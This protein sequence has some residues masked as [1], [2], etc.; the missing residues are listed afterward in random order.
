MKEFRRVLILIFLVGPLISLY[1]TFVLK[2][3]WNWFATEAL[4]LPEIPFWVM[5]GL[6][7]MIGMFTAKLD[8]IEQK[9]TFK[10]F[11]TALDACVPSDQKEWVREQLEGQQESIWGDIAMMP[12]TRILGATFTLVVGWAVHTFLL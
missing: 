5:F 9:Y 12:F 6:V 1:M 2:N 7:L 8:D 10:A 11:G 4:H 3:L